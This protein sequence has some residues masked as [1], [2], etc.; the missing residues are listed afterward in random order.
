MTIEESKKKLKKDGYTSFELSDFNMK[1]YEWLLPFKCNEEIN[2]MD[3]LTSLR[4]DF[5]NTIT[6]E[7]VQFRKDYETHENAKVKQKE[8]LDFLKNDYIQCSQMWYYREMNEIVT[9]DT[10][11]DS[12]KNHIKNMM[13]ELFD[14]KETQEY[15]LFAPSFT[16]YNNGCHL[17][18][19]SDGTGTGR[20]CAVLIYLNEIYDENDG[21]ILVLNNDEQILPTFGKVAIIDLQTFDIKHMVTQVTGGMGRYALLSFVKTKEEEFLNY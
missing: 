17:Q 12:Y 15:S 6:N 3:K 20:I 7:R 4:I 19:H 11:L 8:V 1:F 16:Y 10:D 5:Q 18:N 21:G 13:I 2:L 9:L 14:F